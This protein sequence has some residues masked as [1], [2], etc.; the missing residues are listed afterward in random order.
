MSSSVVGSRIMRGW[1]WAEVFVAL[2]FHYYW[3]LGKSWPLA[4]ESTAGGTV[5]ALGPFAVAL[6]IAF[7]L[8]I[9]TLRRSLLQLEP[10]THWSVAAIFFALLCWMTLRDPFHPWLPYAAPMGLWSLGVGLL[11]VA[12]VLSHARGRTHRDEMPLWQA[13]LLSVT[14]GAVGLLVLSG[15]TWPPYFWTVLVLFHTA[16]AALVPRPPAQEMG[17]WA[18]APVVWRVTAAI[19]A[20]GIAFMLHLALLRALRMAPQLG[21]LE[22]KFVDSLSVLSDPVTLFAALAALFVVRLRWQPAGHLIVA[23]VLVFM[24]LSVSWV[25][26]LALGYALVALFDVTRRIEG[27]AYVL[28]AGFISFAWTFWQFGSAMSGLVFQLHMGLEG[29]Q[30]YIQL[31]RIDLLPVIGFWLVSRLFLRWRKIYPEGAPVALEAL[32]KP[33]GWSVALA[34]PL[35]LLAT[36]IPTLWVWTQ[37]G[38]YPRPVAREAT[39][40]VGEP[41]GVCHAGYSGSDAE[42]ASLE[43]LGV[44]LMRVDFSW[45]GIEREPGNWNF[46]RWDQYVQAAE[47]HSVDVLALLNFDNNAVEQDPDGKTRDRYI[48]PADVPLFLDYVRRTVERYKERVAAW[49]IWNEPD[50]PRFWTGT[51]EEFYDLA[52]QTAQ[53]VREVHPSA[54]ILGPAMTG[55]MGVWTT[56]MMEGMYTAG[57]MVDV[58]HPTCHLYISDP[59]AYYNEY[60]KVRSLALKCGHGGAPWITETGDPDGGVYP[61]RASPEAL[62]EHAIKS[63]TIATSLGFEKV[64]WYCYRDGDAKGQRDRPANSEAFFGLVEREGEW[65]PAA[66]AYSLFSKYCSDSTLRDDLLN[67]GGGMGARQL[68]STLYRKDDGNSTLILWL[69][70]MLR[71]GAQA[72]VTMDFG[73]VDGTPIVHDI[74][75]PYTKQ[76]LDDRIEV[77]ESPIFI[78]YKA[79]ATEGAVSLDVTTSPADALI[80]LLL[81][82]GVAVTLLLLMLRPPH[83]TRNTA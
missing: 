15:M 63:Y 26:T 49:E 53:A 12:N 44:R 76:L 22:D 62:A 2:G 55:P 65:K 20:G 27:V 28:L 34:C 3:I 72:R 18:F 80:L 19:E 25:N 51:E 38:W 9:P 71:P 64:V 36:A 57:A 6:L 33:P 47:A 37:E 82:G 83:V 8:W 78:T 54:V 17:K 48:A 41:S 79:G 45:G 43:A 23:L 59:R 39:V 24:P 13:L 5:L 30:K 58:D 14:I 4:A 77:G 46:S 10:W 68:R 31:Q 7:L 75:S 52:R 40:S 70:P 11:L 21:T 69:E 81:L 50:M 42:Y 66:H 60:S 56:P 1:A 35:V 29:V 73:N 74:G 16:Q 67:V 32:R 61:W